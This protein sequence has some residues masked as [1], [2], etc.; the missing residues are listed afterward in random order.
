MVEKHETTV[1]GLVHSTLMARLYMPMEPDRPLQWKARQLLWNCISG[2]NA[3]DFGCKNYTLTE[4]SV[5]L[6]DKAAIRAA[7]GGTFEEAVAHLF[8]QVEDEGLLFTQTF[9]GEVS[10][11]LLRGQKEE[12]EEGQVPVT[13]LVTLTFLVLSFENVPAHL[14]PREKAEEF[15]RLIC[16]DSHD[17]KSWGTWESSGVV[18]AKVEVEADKHTEAITLEATGDFLEDLNKQWLKRC[19]RY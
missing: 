17:P 19:H 11:A 5:W 2:F 4:R 9:P 18:A 8:K 13:G 1:V 16:L 15:V 6:L 3:F 7:P 12:I 10:Q 14:S